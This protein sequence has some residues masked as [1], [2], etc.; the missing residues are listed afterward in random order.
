MLARRP[1]GNRLVRRV[2]LASMPAEPSRC[3]AAHEALY[4]DRHMPK[5]VFM[6]PQR[7][8]TRAWAAALAEQVPE[9][10][11]VAPE[12]VEEARREIA[13]A[14]AAFGTIPPDLLAAAQQL[15]WLQAPAIA[16]PA[17]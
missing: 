11:V 14:D 8:Q 17:G 2:V 5:C 12:D 1:N 3:I 13:D 15:K 6:P 9:W 16:P 10:D 7:E 4:A